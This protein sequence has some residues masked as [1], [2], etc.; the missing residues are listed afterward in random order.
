VSRTP[1]A[2]ACCALLAGCGTLLGAS[3]DDEPNI[4]PATT[5]AGAGSDSAVTT[6][7]GSVPGNGCETHCLVLRD[8]FERTDTVKGAWSSTTGTLAL[9][10]D[11]G[12]GTGQA[13]VAHLGAG[14]GEPFRESF[15]EK[16]I[17]KSRG[18]E[19]AFTIRATNDAGFG[20]G[21]LD[22]CEFASLV[23]GTKRVVLLYRDGSYD[24]LWVYGLNEASGLEYNLGPGQI[25]GRM[26]LRMTWDTETIAV[27]VLRDGTEVGSRSNAVD[28]NAPN[29]QTAVR[30]GLR[31]SGTTPDID[32]VADDVEIFSPP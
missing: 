20:P 15:L 14:T 22:Y 4:D 25:V 21:Y 17:E 28:P 30:V 1:G 24:Y 16:T 26:G 27:K 13:L 8:E 32:V 23:I 9:V 18:V 19:V 12:V 31:C 11:T 5:D 2:L 7:G 29:V 10:A 3:S 6:E